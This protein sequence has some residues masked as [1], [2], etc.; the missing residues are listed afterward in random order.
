MKKKD[1][2]RIRAKWSHKWEINTG[3]KNACWRE[4]WRWPA[5]YSRRQISMR[6][7]FVKYKRNWI[8]VG[9]SVYTKSFLTGFSPWLLEIDAASRTPYGEKNVWPRNRIH[10][11]PSWELNIFSIGRLS[12]SSSDSLQ[13]D[14]RTPK[15]SRGGWS[16]ELLHYEIN[17]TKI[18]F[19]F[20][21]KIE[22]RHSCSTMVVNL[23]PRKIA[24]TWIFLGIVKKLETFW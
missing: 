20:R 11:V 19:S 8:G 14:W 4:N 5:C 10:Y 12:F 23:M 7:E 24:L 2:I 17:H 18:T 9:E 6:C 3:A 22:I 15:Q 1:Q 13:I 16:T 21:C